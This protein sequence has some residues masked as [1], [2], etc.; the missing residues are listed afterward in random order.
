MVAEL[1]PP[2]LL[3]L[4]VKL[5]V[6]LEHEL[7]ENLEVFHCQYV[8]NIFVVQ[9]ILELVQQQAKLI[10][11]VRQDILQELVQVSIDNGLILSV[12]LQFFWLVILRVSCR[13]D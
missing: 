5:L 3:R 6:G 10:F 8:Q 9:L 4:A 11:R 13:E 7:V 2:I 1:S 12:D